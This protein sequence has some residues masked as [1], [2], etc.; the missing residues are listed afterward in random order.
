MRIRT[1]YVALTVA[2]VTMTGLVSA[3]VGFISASTAGAAGT[4]RGFDGKTILVGG[5]GPLADFSGAQIGAEAYFNAVNATNYLKGVKI[6]FT[7]FDN[8]DND[9]ATALSVVR[10]LVTQ[11]QV[12]AIV[13]DLSTVNPGAYLKSQQV[14]YV[15]FAFDATYCSSSPST[16]IWGFGYNG[17]LVS[18]NP[19]KVPDSYGQFYS[20]VKQKTGQSHPTIALVSA[21]NEAGAGAAALNTVGAK[22]AGFSV[23]YNR[24]SIPITVSDYTPY[25]EQILSSASGKSPTAVSCLIAAQCIGIWT[26]LKNVGYAGSFLTSLGPIAALS[27]SLAGTVTAGF[28]NTNPNAGLTTMENQIES[29]APGTSLTGYANVSAYFAA[30]MFVQAVHQVQQKKEVITPSNVQRSL[31]TIKWS[32]PGLV[33][34]IEYP[35]STVNS[36]PYCAELAAYTGGSIKVVDP[37]SC[38]TRTFKATPSAEKAS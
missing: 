37:Y 27:A 3:G 10:Q 8:D 36:T 21:A 33:G 38:S 14:P 32:I 26:A 7:D 4:V 23:V 20:Y 12:F 17:C 29:F 15:G 19:P 5:V 24:G 28:Y 11:Q 9:P 6:K 35:A 25:V 22:G 16:S 18:S 34:P 1:R 2:I 30:N 13:P 31:S